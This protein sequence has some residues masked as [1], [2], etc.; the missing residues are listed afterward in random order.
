MHYKDYYIKY[1]LQ[2]FAKEG[3]GGEKTEAATPKK[4]EDSRKEGQV[5]KSA[6]INMATSLLSLFIALKV[7][8]SFLGERFIGAF[9]K[10]YEAIPRLVE[11]GPSTQAFQ[12]IVNNTLLD[13]LIMLAPFLIVALVVAF[14]SN[15]LQFKWK[16]T[17]KP[18]KPKL[19]KINPLSGF[20]RMFSVNTLIQFVKAVLKII[21]ISYIVY[22]TISTQ[23]GMLYDFYGLSIE[24][25]LGL[26]F[27]LIIDIGIKCSV[28]MLI[29]GF[30]D[31][32]YQKWKYKED[33][34][35]SKQEVKDEY[36]NSEGDPKVKAQQ[37]QR[38]FQAAQRRMMDS[39]PKADVVITNP[40]HFAVALSYEPGTGRAPIVV[41]K[42]ADF[43]AA[44]IKEIAK[45]HSVEIYEDK[46]L[47]RMLYYNVNLDQEI[48]EELYK[49]VAE[50]IAYVYQ[51]KSKVV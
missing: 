42:G 46:K 30:A 12:D 23:T 35:M 39:V 22:N 21:A 33:N 13:M 47:A 14:L 51:I 7:F 4:L 41:A 31:F 1:N 17:T 32:L 16:V 38:M 15:I 8:I 40:T 34:K 19:S 37:K 5:A 20:K 2:F 27:D 10:Y 25:S 36:K 24:Q 26:L 11:E 45:E 44:K 6:E 43:V 50:V 29:I 49:S 3:P 9:K 48:P 18:M 28:L